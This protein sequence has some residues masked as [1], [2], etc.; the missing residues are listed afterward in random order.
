MTVYYNVINILGN[1]MVKNPSTTITLVGSSEKG[2]EDGVV[3]AE[4]IK[5][6]LVNVFEIKSS[7]ITTK[8]Q[9]KPN[10]PSEQ[11]EGTK[12]LVLLR[13]G[14]RRVSI[15]SNSP[16][17]LM[18]FQSGPDAPLKPL[19]FVA[20]QEAPSSSYIVF[21]ATGANVAYSS[22]SLQITDPDGKLKSF[23]PYTQEK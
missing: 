3:M 17:L 19:E 8:G 11:P 7:R 12:E 21:D 16:E 20:V 15:E 14:D 9:L 5:T 10:I 1:R 23:G 22:W 13:E 18:E 4:S 2:S 6:Y